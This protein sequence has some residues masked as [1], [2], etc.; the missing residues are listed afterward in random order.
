MVA[1]P[2]IP[3]RHRLLIACV[4]ALIGLSGGL[5]QMRSADWPAPLLPLPT[6][7]Q[8][9]W[10]ENELTLFV[11]FGINTFTGQSVGLGTE[12][13]NVFNPTDLDCAQWA[14]VARACGFKGIILTA[15]AADGFC[16]WPT[17]TTVHSVRSSGW[18]DG[19]GDVVRD[20]ANACRAEGV[21]LGISCSPWDLTEPFYAG[22]AA[23]Y[24]RLYRA[25]LTE[26]L[27]HY[28]PVFEL[29][30]DGHNADVADWPAVLALVRKLQ[31]AAAIRQGPKLASIR[32]DVRA[33]EN[34]VGVASLAAW[35]VYPAPDQPA[36][37]AHLWFPLERDVP[38]N[39]H[40]FWDGT[41]PRDLSTLLEDYY[42]S[43]G[44]NS[45]LLLDVAPDRRGR[46]S[47]ESVQRLHEF[48]AALDQIFTTDFAAGRPATA[49]NFR[50]RDP[51][52]GPARALDQRSR[53]AWAT[54][55]GVINAAMEVDLGRPVTFNVVRME[56]MIR[57]GQRV[58]EYRVDAWQDGVWRTIDRGSAIG[59]RKLDRIA[60]VL[61][62]KVR[63][64]IV[65]AR[66]CPVIRSFGL[67]L[68][69]I[70]PASDFPPGPPNGEP[71]ALGR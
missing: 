56:E 18:R 25:Q 69:S 1:A 52:F 64:T 40:R 4:G 54:D 33:P 27:T 59:Y 36:T 42:A 9:A 34:D 17:A 14:R 47:A 38:L 37:K 46:F 65:R 60:P 62:S 31:P 49:T 7:V 57:L 20:L 23:T 39:G 55:E 66:A 70:S 61:A 13:P 5:P 28:G 22:D 11:H 67:H 19:R 3:H 29:W 2:M 24:S 10:Q 58:E 26:L 51:A 50:G 44:D 6:P 63:F 45:S 35:S 12:D 15:K 48:R 21:K 68:D 53:T 71:A 16:L 8:I 41:P 32:E 30:F 43:V